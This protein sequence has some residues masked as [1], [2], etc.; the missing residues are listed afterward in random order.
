MTIALLILA[1][2]AC[3]YVLGACVCRLDLQSPGRNTRHSWA[4]VYLVM[5]AISAWMLADIFTGD[6]TARDIVMSFGVA[7]YIFISR[8]AW[9]NGTAQITRKG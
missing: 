8:R 3:L 6:M 5:A 1:G 4:L 9:G 2:L 7:F